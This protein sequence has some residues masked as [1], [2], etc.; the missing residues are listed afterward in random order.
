LENLSFVLGINS[1][2]SILFY[3]STVLIV[4]LFL[5]ILRFS[6]QTSTTFLYQ[7]KLKQ[8]HYSNSIILCQN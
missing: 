7:K 1:T 4:G 2:I 6:T 8:L 5:N 3:S